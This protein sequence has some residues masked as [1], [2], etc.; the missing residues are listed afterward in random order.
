MD[1][2]N[3]LSHSTRPPPPSPLRWV[4][5]TKFLLFYFLFRR[6]EKRS[7]TCCARSSPN[8]RTRSVAFS[9]TARATTSPRPAAASVVRRPA[10]ILW[11]APPAGAPLPRPGRTASSRSAHR[12]PWTW[13]RTMSGRTASS[14]WTRTRLTAPPPAA[15]MIRMS[16]D[17]AVEVVLETTLR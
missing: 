3:A 6:S 17:M 2:V 4:R 15:K 5:Q 8:T 1:R 16:A 11:A 14:L 10:V 7:G 9:A 12:I 13:T